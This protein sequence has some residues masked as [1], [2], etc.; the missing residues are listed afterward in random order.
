MARHEEVS[1]MFPRS[2]LGRRRSYAEMTLN[3]KLSGP[4]QADPSTK[5]RVDAEQSRSIERRVEWVRLQRVERCTTQWQPLESLLTR[6]F[7]KHVPET[8][9]IC[10]RNADLVLDVE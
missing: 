9:G 6:P 2:A 3:V 5:L 10:D 8:T 7:L 1:C 4:E